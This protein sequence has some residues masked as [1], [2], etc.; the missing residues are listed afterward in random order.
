MQE[1]PDRYT[2][3]LTKLGFLVVDTHEQ[4]PVPAPEGTP[5]TFGGRYHSRVAASAEADRLSAEAR[6]GASA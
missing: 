5:G 3:T 4:R 2:A 6:E 1:Q